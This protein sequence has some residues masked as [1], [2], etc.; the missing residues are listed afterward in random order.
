MA[1]LF[2]ILCRRGQWS[3]LSFRTLQ[4][5]NAVLDALR[6]QDYR[7]ASSPL[8]CCPSVKLSTASQRSKAF[9]RSGHSLSRIEYH[10]VSRLWPLTTMCWRKV[11]S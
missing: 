4:R 7:N 10:S 8:I 11:P 2:F 1:S 9:C 6:P 3:R 5:G